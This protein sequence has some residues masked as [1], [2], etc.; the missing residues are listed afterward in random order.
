MK[1][2]TLGI[3]YGS[4][5]CKAVLFNGEKVVD[6]AIVKSGWQPEKIAFNVFENLLKN[7]NINKEQCKVIS[8]GYGRESI[9][10]ADK[11][12]TEITAHSLGSHFICPNINGIIDIG[13]Q[14]SKVIKIQNGKVLNFYMNDKCAAGTGRFLDMACNTLEVPINDLDSFLNTDEFVSI[15][16]MCTVFAETEII[17]LMSSSTPREL[18]INGVLHS[19]SLRINSMIS[20]LQPKKD[21]VFMMT[22]GLSKSDK[23]VKIISDAIGF[24]IITNEDGQFAGALGAAISGA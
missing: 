17:G 23:I 16:S 12:L 13:G 9:G 10:F 4:T 21:N 7:N 6:K 5:Y 14:D 2:Y 18:I 19:V 24:K 11:S 8:T 1:R 15:N 20:K 22:G 3:D